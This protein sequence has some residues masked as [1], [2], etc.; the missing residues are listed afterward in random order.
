MRN[1]D[2]LAERLTHSGG[3]V[4]KFLGMFSPF[5]AMS[6]ELQSMLQLQRPPACRAEHGRLEMLLRGA[7]ITG[8]PL[9]QR[10]ALARRLAE[11]ARPL[12]RANSKRKQRRYAER[13]IAVVFED[14]AIVDDGIATSR[15]SYV[16]S[17]DYEAGGRS[18][19]SPMRRG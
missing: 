7:G 6:R 15:F 8:Q 5:M 16:A 11:A 3:M 17:H 4:E 19:A 18:S 2:P 9:E 12:L 1:S 14:E 13:A 10:V